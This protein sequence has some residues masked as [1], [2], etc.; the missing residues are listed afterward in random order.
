MRDPRAG[1]VRAYRAGGRRLEFR[2]MRKMSLLCA[3]LVTAAARG[4]SPEAVTYTLTPLPD[5]ARLR[6]EISW[7]TGDRTQSALELGMR[8]GTVADV[9]A[10]LRNVEFP[11]AVTGVKKR[12]G[13]W[14]IQHAPGA[15]VTCRYEV[16]PGR[17][18]LD[19][20]GPHYPLITRSYAHLMGNTFLLVP[21]TGD[22]MPDTY[23]VALRWKLPVG[24]K[25]VCSWG[26]GPGIGDRLAPAD[27]RNSVYLA[28][29]FQKETVER[30]GRRITV[31]VCD[32]FNFRASEFAGLADTIVGH[33]CRFAN[34]R[35]FP[36][37]LVTAAP[38]G[39]STAPGQTR[40][41]GMGLYRSFVLLAAPNAK[42]DDAFASLFAH[43]LF[44][45]WNGRVLKAAQP[46]KLVY[47][48]TEGF[49]EYYA[50]RILLDSG[51]WTPEVYARWV[52]RHLRQY[53]DNPAMHATNE[54]IQAGYWQARDTI[55]EVPYQRGV[56]LGLRW[57][58]QAR[59]RGIAN[60]MDALFLGLLER[61][62]LESFELTNDL[63]RQEGVRV[64]GAWFGP[65][66]DKYVVQAE[67]VDVPPEV[68]E[69]AL[70]GV[71][72]DVYAFE[73][74]FD[75]GIAAQKKR[76]RNLVPNS[77]AQ[78]AGLREGDRLVQAKVQPDPDQ[79]VELQV[80]RDGQVKKVRFYPRGTRRAVLQFE[81]R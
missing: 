81:P 32:D 34:E 39:G 13:Q 19:W 78:R 57:H 9:P 41:V 53:R 36:P 5:A 14:L 50:L 8:W 69:P 21:H 6:V 63:L 4:Q 61:A 47:W 28:G 43:E 76:V 20:D 77:P 25:A 37:L 35:E 11:G 79:E 68:L 23:E 72:R 51:F 65:E 30:D 62:R 59:Q 1:P 73:L 70:R 3:V 56:L 64:L 74:G 80:A 60:G 52:N 22:G 29:K 46:D 48:F 2:V 38:V 40:L 10:L 15:Q 49:T 55:G 18:K 17:R 66:F 26:E 45:H 58:R 16:D 42:L 44:H 31:A 12:G 67:T 7:S 54:E 33:E 71:Y 27:L 75:A 24:W